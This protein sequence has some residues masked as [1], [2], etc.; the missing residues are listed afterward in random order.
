MYKHL[1]L[2]IHVTNRIKNAPELQVLFTQYGANIKTRLGLHEVTDKIDSPA[3]V[4]V[5]EMVGDEDRFNE[6]AGK[7]GAIEGVDVQKVVF[8]HE[9]N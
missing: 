1:L 5:L 3:A 9:T 7:V 4:M 2:C 8:S 6:L